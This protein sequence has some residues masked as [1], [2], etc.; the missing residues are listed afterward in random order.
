MSILL[1]EVCVIDV[2][3]LGQLVLVVE[4]VVAVEE[5]GLM[6][7]NVE[8]VPVGLLD[9]LDLTTGHVPCKSEVSTRIHRSCLIFFCLDVSQ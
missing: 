7:E 8:G 2:A 5:V 1:F 3:L 4:A 9:S 6:E